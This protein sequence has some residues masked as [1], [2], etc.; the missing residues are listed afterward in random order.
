[1]TATV[2]R[3]EAAAWM[4]PLAA[5]QEAEEGM[6][7][8]RVAAALVGRMAVG[9]TVRASLVMAD[10][11]GSVAVQ[12][13]SQAAAALVEAMEAVARAAERVAAAKGEAVGRVAAMD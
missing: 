3:V 11:A 1:M 4:A 2:V 7:A 9:V 13:G 10:E 12:A 8:A 6:V 5:T